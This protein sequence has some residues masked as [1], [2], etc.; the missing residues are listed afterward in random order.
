MGAALLLWS[1]GGSG[2]TSSSSPPTPAATE[3]RPPDS[4]QPGAGSEAGRLR[5][6]QHQTS[7]CYVEGQVSHLIVRNADGNEIVN[8]AFQTVNP[9]SPV[10][11]LELDPG[12]YEVESYQQPCAGNCDY[13]D[14]PTD[15][16]VTSV[17]VGAGED[18]FLTAEFAPGEG[19]RLERTEE[20]LP[21]PVPDEFALREPY[22]DCG[23]DFSLDSEDLSFGSE[24]RCFIDANTAGEPAEL[25]SYE[26]GRDP[27]VPD[28]FVY[29][30]NA[31]RT[32]DVFLPNLGR[33]TDGPWRRYH[34]DGLTEDRATGFR[35]VGCTDPVE[36]VTASAPSTTRSVTTVVARFSVEYEY[37]YDDTNTTYCPV[38]GT[39]FVDRSSG[40]PTSWTWR[41]PDGSTST[42]QHPHLPAG[43]N[44]EVTLTVSNGVSSDETT[45]SV[46]A[47]EC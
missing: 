24:R 8:R 23:L 26:S 29:R 35:L 7:C 36:L 28:F 20:P 47:V 21:S 13:L 46:A 22:R 44:G 34:C 15:R 12:D 32:L 16:C 3:E 1:C 10:V 27:D 42:E 40:Q 2:S 25:S 6:S 33:A 11:D 14:P 18:V 37:E 17:A 43:V 5:I 45:Q 4:T 39:T 19:C 30:S 31:D 38:L 9:A 41:F